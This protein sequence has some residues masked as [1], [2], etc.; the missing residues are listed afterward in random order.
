MASKPQAVKTPAPCKRCL[1]V[2]QTGPKCTKCGVVS[3]SSCVGLLKNIK[4]IDEKAIICCENDLQDNLQSISDSANSTKDAEPKRDVSKMEISYLKEL[5]GQKDLIILNQNVAIKSLN[6]QIDLLNKIN[7]LN[8]IMTKEPSSAPRK[9]LELPKPATAI[10]KQVT[11]A[12]PSL[13]VTPAVAAA[14]TTHLELSIP[15]VSC[16]KQQKQAEK[17]SKHISKSELSRAVHEAESLSKLQEIIHVNDGPFMEVTHKNKRKKNAPMIGQMDINNQA[18]LK[19][20]KRH[21]FF[22]VYKTH[23]DTTVEELTTFLKPTFPDVV[24]DKL[25][26]MYPHY[27]SSFKVTIDES[28][29]EKAMKPSSWP[30]GAWVNK[31]FHRRKME[32]EAG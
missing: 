12:Q 32:T 1:K 30:K 27:Y 5:L 20:I 21:S 23:P 16:Q 15:P 22:H 4:V 10:S 24:C 17:K 8:S 25:N 14:A 7:T 26:S 31:F 13:D 19:M 9:Q 6:E 29:L 2:A 18:S 3:H 28:D 11:A